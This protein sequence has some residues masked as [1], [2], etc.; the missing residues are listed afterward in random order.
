[1]RIGDVGLVEVR[2]QHAADQPDVSAGVVSRRDGSVKQTVIGNRYAFRTAAVTDPEDAVRVEVADERAAGDGTRLRLVDERVGVAKRR[3]RGEERSRLRV[4]VVAHHHVAVRGQVI[5]DVV[6]PPEIVPIATA[7]DDDGESAHRGDVGRE[8]EVLPEL[9]AGNTEA[10][11]NAGVEV[12]DHFGHCV[13]TGS[14]S[15]VHDVEAGFATQAVDVVAIAQRSVLIAVEHD[16]V[17]HAE[18]RAGVGVQRGRRGHFEG[19]RLNRPGAERVHQHTAGCH[20]DERRI[21]GPAGRALVVDHVG[22]AGVAYD[23]GKAR[24]IDRHFDGRVEVERAH[25]FEERV[26][27]EGIA[28][29]LRFR[30]RRLRGQR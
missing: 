14:R 17:G 3:G 4:V 7:D 1:M 29:E 20:V 15:V 8:V 10:S 28:G 13:R 21:R 19:V 27:R 9:V 26:L 2:G 5:A 25:I 6:V 22:V 30:D 18:A 11:G 12:V 23:C 16:V 24:G